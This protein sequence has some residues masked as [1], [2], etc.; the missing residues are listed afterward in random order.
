MSTVRIY[1][2]ISGPVTIRIV[3]PPRC[4]MMSSPP[5]LCWSVV[6]GGAANSRPTIK[7]DRRV[8]HAARAT[9]DALIC[10]N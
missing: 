10:I 6:G 4:F 9:N 3:L 7:D 1:L 2:Y 8:C 5:P